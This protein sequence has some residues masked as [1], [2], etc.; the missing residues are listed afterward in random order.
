[1]IEENT[2]TLYIIKKYNYYNLIGMGGSSLGAKGIYS[3]LNHKIKKKFNFV[4]N[5]EINKIN[6]RHTDEICNKCIA[7]L[8]V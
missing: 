8:T 4:D 2:K 5:L 3:F 6:S 7:W 1:M